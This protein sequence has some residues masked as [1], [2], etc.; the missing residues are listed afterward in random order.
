MR[1]LIADAVLLADAVQR[2][3]GAGRVGDVVV[4]VVAG[5]PARHRALL[6]AIRQPALL[7]RLE[8]RDEAARSKSIRFSV[9][10]VLLIAADESAD[11]VDAEQRRGV[12]HAQHE[13]VLLR[14]DRRV[15]VQQVVEVA[16]V[17]DADARRLR[18]PPRPACARSLSNGLRRSSVLATGS[19]IASGGTSDFA[20][21]ERRRQLDVVGAEVLRELQPVLDR[22]V[23]IG[24]RTSRGVSSCSAAVRT[25]TFMNFGSNGRVVI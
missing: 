24:S 11:R 18:A 15:V 9:H 19:S 21:M 17:R 25:P 23:R 10:A 1:K 6:D 22:L 3:P 7:R 20:R 2:D 4:P 14:A 8:Q 12:E 5:R 13:V 16:D